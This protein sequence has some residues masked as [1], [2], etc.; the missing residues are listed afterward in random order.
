MIRQEPGK[1][2][3]TQGLLF[4][5]PLA[6]FWIMQSAGFSLWPIYICLSCI[7]LAVSLIVIGE[8][9]VSYKRR[10]AKRRLGETTGDL[11]FTT[12]II[13]AYLPNE[14][15]IILDTLGHVLTTVIRPRNGLEVILAYN[16][17]HDLPVEQRLAKLAA[18]YPELKLLRVA[19]SLSKAENL[20]AA[21]KMA[22]GE[23]T[24]LFDAD[25]HPAPD[26]LSRAWRWLE[27]EYHAVQGTNS[28]RNGSDNLLTRL[29]SIEFG[30]IYGITHPGKSIISDSTVFG[31]SN[32]YWR[33]EILKELCFDPAML[34]EDID[35]TARALL[36]GYKIV[37]DR[38]I[39]STELA[40]NT[41]R[42]FWFQRKRW[43]QGWLQVT[44]KYQKQILLSPKLNSCQKI[45][46]TYLLIFREVNYLTSHLFLPLLTCFWIGEA[47]MYLP[48]NAFIIFTII[49]GQLSVY[50][51]TFVTYKRN[52]RPIAGVWY[53]VYAALNIIYGALKNAISIVAM[54]DEIMQNKKWVVT[55][56]KTFTK[57]GILPLKPRLITPNTS[58]KHI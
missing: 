34:T 12:I 18:D 28:I 3:V 29:I 10:Y 49:V 46:W 22:Q 36:K 35:I 41:L 31:G 56:R 39:V 16:T 11:P 4:I 14:A 26:C 2:V 42:N 43:S 40:P 27:K 50:M 20:N 32:G 55:E 6:C 47:R 17:P 54:L 8:S 48:L 15:E 5:F 1:V 51:Q 38:S 9:I 25:H 7:H 52:V 37:H 30:A 44:L 53:L 21:L 23:M 13:P 19:G 33:T 24:A 58:W 45:Y 57:K